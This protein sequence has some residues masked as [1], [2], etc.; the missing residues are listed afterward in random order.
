MQIEFRELKYP[1]KCALCEFEMHKGQKAVI[2]SSAFTTRNHVLH[3]ECVEQMKDFLD[4]ELEEEKP[5]GA[6]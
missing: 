6:A 3:V 1:V 2:V 5:N 4:K